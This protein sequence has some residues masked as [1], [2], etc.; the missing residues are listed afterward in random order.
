MG[1][2]YYNQAKGTDVQVLG[3]DMEKQ[4]GAHPR[5]GAVDVV[6]FVPIR[7]ISMQECVHLARGLGRRVGEELG[8]PVYLYEEAALVPERVNLENIRK[9]QYESLKAEIERN[10]ARKPDFGPAK[11]GRAGATVIGAREAL[12]AFNVY[13][14]TDDVSIAKAIAKTIRFSSGGLRYVKAMGVLVG[15]RAQVSMN[16]TNYRKTSIALVVETIRREA[17]RYGV[18]IHHS[19]LVGLAPQEAL[20][21]AAVWYTQL[22]QFQADQILENRLSEMYAC[23]SFSYSF[24]DALANPQPTP[25][26]GSA[27]AFTA[28]EAAALVVMVGRLTSGR[29]K[30]EAVENEIAQIVQ[31]AE[32][33]R[34]QLTSAV[35]KDAAAFD[36]LMT[37]IKL[38][39]STDAE[40]EKRASALAEASLHAS[41]VPLQTAEMAVEVLRLADRVIEIGYINAVTDGATASAL[42]RAA[43]SAAGAN[44]RINLAGMQEDE[45]A[46]ALLN[47]IDR[48]ENEAI[49]IYRRIQ[50]TLRRRVKIELL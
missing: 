35:E 21:N 2:D 10:P 12:I 24:I 36:A 30:Y 40:R 11:L 1:V 16:L 3:W 33:L 32:E 28:A 20:V 15:G 9:G 14:T 13:L 34:L 7:D 49:E 48:L 26:G 46:L 31:Q 45:R 22:D 29:K 39:K 19:E 38:P 42:C 5:I 44:V 25:G 50:N 6:P 27:A 18:A 37:A 4:E 23:E 17:Q 41:E 43:V 47:K 8:I